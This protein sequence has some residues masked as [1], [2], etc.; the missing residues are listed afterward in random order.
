[1][2]AVQKLYLS[3]FERNCGLWY[4]WRMQRENVS[5]RFQKSSYRRRSERDGCGDYDCCGIHQFVV[6]LFDRVPISISIVTNRIK[7]P[8]TLF[9]ISVVCWRLTTNTPNICSIPL[10]AIF[11]TKYITH[12]SWLAVMD[13]MSIRTPLLSFSNILQ[14]VYTS[15]CWNCWSMCILIEHRLMRMA[16]SSTLAIELRIEHTKT[17]PRHWSYRSE[18]LCPF[19]TTSIYSF[20]VALYLS[21]WRRTSYA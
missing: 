13:R 9:V 11:F 19:C 7:S 14:T 17:M 21:D 15:D 10:F 16:V 5:M 8:T 20:F 2:S 12:V 1:M 3:W 4:L 18:V 6:F